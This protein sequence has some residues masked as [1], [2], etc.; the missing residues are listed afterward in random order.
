MGSE[1]SG[2]GSSNSPNMGLTILGGMRSRRMRSR[3]LLLD[4]SGSVPSNTL[5][6]GCGGGG[7]GTRPSFV[8]RRRGAR[9]AV[10]LAGPAP[11]VSLRYCRTESWLPLCPSEIGTNR[12]RDGRESPL[13]LGGPS[14]VSRQTGQVFA[15]LSHSWATVNHGCTKKRREKKINL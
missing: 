3:P 6:S 4:D 1:Y 12:T 13:A 8:D 7:G 9:G 10:M 14:T 15:V 11:L 5:V 2:Q